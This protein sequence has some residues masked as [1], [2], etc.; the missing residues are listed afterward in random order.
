[1]LATFAVVLLLLCVQVQLSKGVVSI[2]H[3]VIAVIAKLPAER[4]FLQSLEGHE[5]VLTD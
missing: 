5:G 4:Y 3:Y 2:V 1:M